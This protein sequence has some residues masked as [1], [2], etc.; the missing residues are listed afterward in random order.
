MSNPFYSYDGAFIPGQLARAESVA[1][2]FLAVQAGFSLLSYDGIDS[3]SANAF[4]ITTGGAPTGAY[5][6]GQVVRFQA[7]STNTAAATITVNGIPAVP[8]TRFDGS[9]LVSNDV[10]VRSFITAQYD[11]TGMTFR[12]TSPAAFTTAAG[13]VSHAA[14]T[15]KV[16]LTAVGGLSNNVLPIDV[17]FAIDQA[18]SPTWTGNHT[19]NGTV[20]F[21]NVPSFGGG[22]LP[23]ANGGT[24]QTTYTVGDILYASGTAALSKLSA[25][26]AGSYLRSTAVGGAPVW[27]T[28]KIPNAAV[29]GDLWYGS[30]ASTITALAG[31]TTSTKQFLAQTGTGAVSAAPAWAAIA[32]ADLPIAAANPS[33]SVGLTAVNGTS[34]NYIRADGAPALSQAIAPTWTGLHTWSQSL[35]SFSATG[36]PFLK[37]VNTSATAQTPLDFFSNTST[38]TGR[39]RND[40]AGNMTYVAF[41]SGTHTFYVGGDNGVG[42][43]VFNVMSAASGGAQVIDESG[44]LQTVGY[45]DVPVNQQNGAYTTILSDRGKGIFHNSVSPHTHTIAANASVAYPVGTVITFCNANGGGT[46]TIAIN[47]DTLT[48]SATGG[49]G[50]RSLAANG[51]ATAYKRQTTEWLI[52][53]SNLT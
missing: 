41:L 2:E 29:L 38:M 21:A 10:T 4:V 1:A 8:L 45:R 17:T 3:G 49:T 28:V 18:I 13:T 27:S 16:G 7:N 12:I 48:W 37:L 32:V 26:S 31:N 24:G 9:P 42:T 51:I 52:S 50:S 20:I 30:A 14:P 44:T 6:N 34:T 53:G 36:N 46:V 35:G 15:N 47:S 22:A 11:A 43:N 23:A 40:F 33:A 5:S 25:V 19:F 39:V